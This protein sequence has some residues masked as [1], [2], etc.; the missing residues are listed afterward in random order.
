M[1]IT[2]QIKLKARQSRL[3]KIEDLLSGQEYYMAYIVSAPIDGK[4]NEEV[5]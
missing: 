2:V 5:I 3:E 1:K 4:A